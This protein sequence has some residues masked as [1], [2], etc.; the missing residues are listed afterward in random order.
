MC[1]LSNQWSIVQSTIFILTEGNSMYLNLLTYPFLIFCNDSV[2]GVR[3]IIDCG[4]GCN[5]SKGC[6]LQA[7]QDILASLS[8]PC[9]LAQEV[10]C[11]R[12]GLWLLGDIDNLFQ[13]GYTE[14]DIL[15]RHTSIVESVKGHLCGRLTKWL[16]SQGSHHFTRI[17]LKYSTHIHSYTKKK[18]CSVIIKRDWHSYLKFQK[19]LKRTKWTQ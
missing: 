4:V 5:L 1:T 17:Y 7:A 14:G 11:Q 15:G 6:M 10:D 16:S 19:M 13:T 2:H 3:I 12:W 9:C 18:C 8:I